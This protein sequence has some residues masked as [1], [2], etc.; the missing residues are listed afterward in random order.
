MNDESGAK[1]GLSREQKTGF[2][3]LVIFG[4][5][6]VGFG[7]VQLR[8][9][10]YGP[11]VLSLSPDKPISFD[12]DEKTRLQ[13]IDTDQDGLNDYEE[14]EFYGTSPYLPDTDSDTIGDKAEIDAGT[15]PA[16]PEGDSCATAAAVGG[17]ATVPPA[18]L[19][20]TDGIDPVGLVGSSLGGGGDTGAQSSA[21]LSQEEI[22]A[23]IR[24]PEALRQLLLQS[25]K[26]SKEALDKIDDATLVA[27]AAQ[28]A[29]EG[30]PATSAAP[31]GAGQ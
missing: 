6:A 18:P 12:L 11:F 10:I 21:S 7:M 23:L 22:Q 14:L 15:D 4:V 17:G 5:L 1:K 25:G 8:N 27:F 16:C 26:L 20:S 19:V 13:L 3:F 30:Q 9:T 24:D 28:L 2:F 31:T 29:A